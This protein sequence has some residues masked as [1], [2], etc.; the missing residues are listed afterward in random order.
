MCRKQVG[1][2][3]DRLFEVGRGLVGSAQRV[4]D[5]G[6]LEKHARHA[7]RVAAAVCSMGQRFVEKDQR[8]LVLAVNVQSR[9]QDG[10]YHVGHLLRAMR[11]EQIQVS[12]SQRDTGEIGNI[13]DA[14]QT[15]SV[16]G[17]G[18]RRSHGIEH[19]L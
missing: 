7:R 18:C 19:K 8:V 10:R 9:C 1:I 11:S 13:A 16:G 5:H 17:F 4:L 6:T 3:L 15:G 14:C 2:E 12:G